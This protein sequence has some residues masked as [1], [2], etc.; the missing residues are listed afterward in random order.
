M[1]AL[2]KI[3]GDEVVLTFV[4]EIRPIL[5]KEAEDDSLISLILPIRTY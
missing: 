3:K 1:E 5:L 2:S 4:G